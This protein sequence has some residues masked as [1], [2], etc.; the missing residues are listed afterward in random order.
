MKIKNDEFTITDT[1]NA[2]SYSELV[3]SIISKLKDSI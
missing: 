1:K 3:T 2:H